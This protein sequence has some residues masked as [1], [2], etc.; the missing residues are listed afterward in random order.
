MATQIDYNTQ[1]KNTPTLPEIP[2]VVASDYEWS[3]TPPTNLTLVAGVESTATFTALPAGLTEATSPN[4]H[5]VGVDVAGGHGSYLITAVSDAAKTIKFTPDQSHAATTWTL[6]SASGGIQ[7]AVY[8]NVGDFIYVP[9]G[10]ILYDAKKVWVNRAN[11]TIRGAG[12]KATILEFTY[13]G[14]DGFWSDT[15]G[16]EIHD[17]RFE[18]TGTATQTAG[19][20]ISLVGTTPKYLGEA[21]ITVTGCE[22]YNMYNGIVYDCPGGFIRVLDNMVRGMVNYAV[23][24]KSS[25]AGALQICDNYMDGVESPGLIWLEQVTSGVIIADNW[26]QAAKT[27]IVINSTNTAA[28]FGVYE[29]VITGNILDNDRLN[30]VASVIVNG[31]GVALTSSNS[32]QIVAN[33]FSSVGFCVL[34]QN[35]Y[36]VFIKANK[37]FARYTN[38]II[39]IAGSTANNITISDNELWAGPNY[40]ISYAIQ[41]SATAID[42]CTI[43]CNKASASSSCTSMIGIA[44]GVTNLQIVNNV[45]G[46]NFAK[47]ITDVSATGEGQVQCRFNSSMNQPYIGTTHTG[48]V[49][50]PLVDQGQFIGLA[51]STSTITAMTGLAARAGN[52]VTFITAAA[53]AWNTSAAS[54]NRIGKAYSSPAAG[55]VI[56]FH[57]FSDNLWYPTK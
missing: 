36:N 23:Y 17:M 56:T 26:M 28:S 20:V 5:Y 47:L 45:C 13:P 15:Y 10:T 6:R 29:V 42:N 48:V 12:K 14:A 4:K 24:H 38:P 16:Y 2:A 33:Y 54:D 34:T 22:F 37:L 50:I 44:S 49:T 53:Q 3:F 31:S 27:H 52:S 39:A 19:A 21:D 32:V 9:M 46:M 57:K 43:M 1:I 11:V 55:D 41:L 35:A 51:A 18:P 40:V 7:E 8:A 30:T 25:V